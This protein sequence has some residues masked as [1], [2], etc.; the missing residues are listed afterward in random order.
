MALTFPPQG[1]PSWMRRVEQALLQNH[2]DIQRLW[3]VVPQIPDQVP[4]IPFTTPLD[5]TR[6]FIP[7]SLGS[8]S[9]SSHNSSPGSTA[10]SSSSSIGSS[11]S[12]TS[13][14]SSGS[15]GSSGSS[16]YDCSVDTCAWIWNDVPVGSGNYEWS[17]YAFLTT[18]DANNGCD[19][20]TPE[21]AGAYYGEIRYTGCGGTAGS[22][23]SGGSS[24]SAAGAS[25]GTCLVEYAGGTWVTMSDNCTDPGGGDTCVCDVPTAPSFEGDIRTT[26]C[27]VLAP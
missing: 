9:R 3:Q 14:S 8:S 6:F 7:S 2:V 24:S 22:S 20:T 13:G 17:P 23:S 15:S 16:S 1:S 10:S 26:N 18:C 25:C 5:P 21:G 27:L 12:T 19:C 11:S 4:G